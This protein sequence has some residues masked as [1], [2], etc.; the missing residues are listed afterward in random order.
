MVF[1]YSLF[2]GKKVFSD[3]EEILSILSQA[4]DEAFL[5]GKMRE[6]VVDTIKGYTVQNK[7]LQYR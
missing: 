4:F 6:G 2:A 1:N 5:W 7:R 3:A